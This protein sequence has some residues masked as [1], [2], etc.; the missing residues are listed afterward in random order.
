MEVAIAEAYH[1]TLVWENIDLPVPDRRSHIY[2]MELS[3]FGLH[4]IGGGF[5]LWDV[6][7]EVNYEPVEIVSMGSNDV[8]AVFAV[9]ES[10]NIEEVTAVIFNGY[11]IEVVGD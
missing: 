1:P 6:I 9:A 10:I 5:R 8:E 4:V 7:I 11:R 2:Y 3:P